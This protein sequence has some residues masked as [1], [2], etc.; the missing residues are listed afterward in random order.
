MTQYKIMIC[1]AMDDETEKYRKLAL[2][3]MSHW[4]EINSSARNIVFIATGQN[5]NTVSDSGVSAQESINEQS[6]KESSEGIF[7]FDENLGT[8][9]NGYSSGTEE[10][11]V[12]FLKMN[13]K[14]RVYLN[15]K[16]TSCIKKILTDKDILYSPYQSKKEFAMLIRDLLDTIANSYLK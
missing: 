13:K 6:L 16:G 7:I 11:L 5:I 4:N 15:K 3:T 12:C 2:E 9:V 14:A 8:P 10:E 1:S